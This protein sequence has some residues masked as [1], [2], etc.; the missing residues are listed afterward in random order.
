VSRIKLTF[1]KCGP[2]NFYFD[3][4]QCWTAVLG[5]AFQKLTH[6][7][8]MFSI[9]LFVT[10]ICVPTWHIWISRIREEGTKYY[11]SAV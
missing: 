4:Y 8:D 5:T 3:S 2:L 9:T 1:I 7:S 11:V 10:W 6:I